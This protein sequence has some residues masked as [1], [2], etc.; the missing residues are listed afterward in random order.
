MSYSLAATPIASLPQPSLVVQKPVM[1][2]PSTLA[3]AIDKTRP[4]SA[5]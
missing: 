3:G 5:G 4:R 1:P 2:R